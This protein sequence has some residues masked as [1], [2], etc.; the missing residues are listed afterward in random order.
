VAAHPRRLSPS[1]PLPP[2]WWSALLFLTVLAVYTRSLNPSLFR[3]DSPET[4]TACVTLGVSHPPGYP[5]HSLLGHIFAMILSVGNPAMTLNF[6]STVLGTVGACLLAIN[7]WLLLGSLGPTH[8]LAASLA[9]ALAFA[10]SKSYWSASLA[11][12]GGIY[13]L[14]VDLELVFFYFLQLH[15]FHASRTPKVEG[16]LKKPLACLVFIF[17]LGL[18]N[19]WPTQLLTLPAVGTLAFVKAGPKPR[20]RFKPTTKSLIQIFVFAL[21]VLSFYLYLPLRANQFPTLNFG[22]PLNWHRFL[23]CL[24]R[25]DYSKV[26]TIASAA[27]S[28]FSALRTKALY[29]SDHFLNEFNGLFLFLT[30]LGIWGLLKKG[31]ERLVLYLLTLLFTTMAVN[32]FYL[33]VIPIEFWHLDDHTLSLNWIL[34]LFGGCGAGYLLEWMGALH[35]LRSRAVAQ[36]ALG[37]LVTV[38]L[39]VMIFLNH[40]HVNDQSREFLYWGYGTT[41]LKSIDPG[42]FY[43]AESDYDYFSILYLQQ[44]ERRR[45]DVSLFLA[46]LLGK[47]AS[48]L[49]PS[50]QRR[51]LIPLPLP[52]FTLNTPHGTP[53]LFCSFP[54]GP[55]ASYKEKDSQKPLRFYFKP[56][57]IITHAFP[58]EPSFNS[59]AN[60][61]ILN[62]FWEQYLEPEKQNANPINGLLLELCAHPYLN[63]ANYLKLKGNLSHWDDLYNQGLSLIQENPWLAQTWEMRAEG[64]VELGKKREATAAYAIS[65]L[66]YQS[67][68][69]AL[70]ERLCLKKA[71]FLDPSN[72]ALRQALTNLETP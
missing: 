70:E 12:K 34:G 10:F 26:E 29:L 69:M 2:G 22:V 48:D 1:I 67:A 5:L 39:P 24:F 21:V 61:K 65:A 11:A 60:L 13:V 68:K 71:L 15:F 51:S 31:K 19:H 35:L 55:V 66:Q 17:T 44:V 52:V 20:I 16:G 56:A 43:Y 3:N 38:A 53:E 49:G 41:A 42:A 32:V 45:P 59:T 28:E 6:F 14:Q 40:Q 18:I 36:W 33:R 37:S 47:D 72:T 62:D 9:S 25:A 8:R 63:T 4:I 30:T 7:L 58:V 46:P 23:A 57:G 50:Q 54:N 27:P 64:E